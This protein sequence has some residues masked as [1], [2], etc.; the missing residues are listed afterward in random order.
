[1]DD[2][3]QR[4]LG[5]A[6]QRLDRA[7]SRGARVSADLARTDINRILAEAMPSKQDEGPRLPGGT[8]AWLRNVIRD[9]GVRLHALERAL[10]ADKV[11]LTPTFEKGGAGLR[12]EIKF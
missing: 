6:C 3:T 4:R 1:M 10:D 2:L 9:R 11:V 12:L 7:L 8:P 5:D